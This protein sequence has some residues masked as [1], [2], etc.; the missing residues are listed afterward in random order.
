MEQ[1]P[2][3]HRAF[4]QQGLKREAEGLVQNVLGLPKGR[5]L[6]HA[7]QLHQGVGLL[8]Q[9][10]VLLAEGGHPKSQIWRGLRC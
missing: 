6:R 4:Q 5:L 1:V 9:F 7:I 8:H 2:L 10:Q 3:L